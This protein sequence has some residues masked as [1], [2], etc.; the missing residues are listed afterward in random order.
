MRKEYLHLIKLPD[1]DSILTKAAFDFYIKKSDEEPKQE[2]ESF[3]IMYDT[4]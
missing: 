4:V 3:S 2:E 1:E